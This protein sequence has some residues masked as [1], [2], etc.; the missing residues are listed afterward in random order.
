MISG[1]E[2]D[3]CSGR[4]MSDTEQP[5]TTSEA[6]K[7]GP[8]AYPTP[9]AM[10]TQLDASGVRFDFNMGAR[11]LLP[12]LEAGQWHIRL[13]DLDTGNIL[14]ES[15]NKGALVASS[16]HFHVRFAIDLWRIDEAGKATVVL[17]HAYDCRDKPVLIQFPVGTL[18]DIL[19]WVPYAAAFAE[20]HGAQVTCAMSELLIPL[21]RD[22]YPGMTFATHEEVMAQGLTDTAYATYYMGLFF[23][24]AEN[25]WQPTDFRHVGLHRTAGYILGVDPAEVRPILGVP[26]EGRPIAEPYV[27]IAV[28]S[29]SACKKWN[30]PHGWREV[31]VDL[32]ARGYR[33]ICIDQKAEHGSGLIWTHIPHGAEDETGDRP[34]AERVRWLR[35]AAFFVGVSSGLSW[36]AWAAGTPVVMISGFTHP[37]NEFHSPY[38]IINWHAC[39]SCWNDVR[40]RFDHKDYMWCPRHAGT[41]RQFECSRLITS[42]QVIQTIGRIPTVLSRPEGD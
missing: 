27:V 35:H 31:I 3:D 32:K 9:A 7:Q 4:T 16:K 14:F 13:R 26:D 20:Q 41:D 2:T 1:R 15:T 33:V 42:A 29:S 22:A 36:L 19:G 18:G 34:L 39:N 6:E 8:P 17:E 5:A 12:P 24:D 38:R 30:N 37:N 40:L 21:F 25:I 28:Q 11:V 10:P 23:D